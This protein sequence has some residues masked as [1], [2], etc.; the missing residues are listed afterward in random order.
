[1]KQLPECSLANI[2]QCSL[3]TLD[4]V[5]ESFHNI[6][7]GCFD[8]IPS[9]GNGDTNCVNNCLKNYRMSFEKIQHALCKH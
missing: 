3:W 9:P 8:L 7:E 4:D 6:I 1:M 5:L 2:L